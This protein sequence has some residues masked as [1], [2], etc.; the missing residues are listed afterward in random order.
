MRAFAPGQMK[1]KMIH[2]IIAKHKYICLAAEISLT[3]VGVPAKPRLRGERR[4]NIVIELLRL[5]RSD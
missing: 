1:P 4:S 5:R 2:T 3:E